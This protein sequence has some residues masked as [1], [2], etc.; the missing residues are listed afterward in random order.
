MNS[1][2]DEKFF[3]AIE[4]GKSQYNYKLHDIRF[5]CAIKGSGKGTLNDT[6]D[7]VFNMRFNG[8]PVASFQ[9]KGN[10]TRRFSNLKIEPKAQFA[11][12]VLGKAPVGL[13]ANH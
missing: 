11:G 5:N 4:T 8:K 12:S 13:V 10:A 7:I 3:K 2:I 1:K 9:I 6:Q